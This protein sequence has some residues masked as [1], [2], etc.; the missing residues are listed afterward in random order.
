[1][2]DEYLQKQQEDDRRCASDNMVGFRLNEFEELLPM[3]QHLRGEWD[4]PDL[5][6]MFREWA[7]NAV[8]DFRYNNPFSD[9]PRDPDTPL[10]W[11]N[12]SLLI[13]SDRDDETT[14]KLL[15]VIQNAYFNVM[16]VGHDDAGISIWQISY[17]KVTPKMT[18][19]YYV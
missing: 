17:S 1:M 14:K 2:S 9:D 10:Y 19:E 13:K 5:M 8:I 18:K 12:T 7:L 16:L 15:Q 4:D 6:E 11:R 3:L